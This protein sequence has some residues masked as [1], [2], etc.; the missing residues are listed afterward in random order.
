MSTFFIAI[1]DWLGHSLFS[2]DLNT[3]L[4]GGDI[5]EEVQNA[6]CHY[7]MIGVVMAVI[8]LLC[9]YAFYKII[10]HPRFS[11]WWAWI[12]TWLSTGLINLLVGLGMVTYYVR[13]AS[14]DLV[15]DNGF[16]S[17]D[18]WGLAF[19]NMVLCLILFFILSLIFM[20]FSTN[21]KYSPFRR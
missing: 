10:D 13:H 7:I 15:P 18:C 14:D 9:V 8:T 16:S 6:P 21:C 5:N 12:I 1:Y 3:F 11:S 4:C 2:S 17:G 19:D 20:F